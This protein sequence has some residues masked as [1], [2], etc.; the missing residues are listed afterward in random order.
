VL[1]VETT[2]HGAIEVAERLRLAI[3]SLEL[4]SATQITA[5]FGVAECP[6]DAQTA[7]DILKAADV[8]LYEAKRAGRDRVVGTPG[9]SNSMAAGDVQGDGNLGVVSR[10]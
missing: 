7:A 3:K 5:S 9:M 2:Q 4:T 8:A 1:L 10:G 6:I